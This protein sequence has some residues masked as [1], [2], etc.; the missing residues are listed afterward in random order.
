MLNAPQHIVSTILAS[1]DMHD[2]V[3]TLCRWFEAET[4]LKADALNAYKRCHQSSFVP[5]GWH[6]RDVLEGHLKS[7]EE[8]GKNPG[9]AILGD[10]VLIEFLRLEAEHS[11][12]TGTVV[13][14]MDGCVIEAADVPETTYNNWSKSA[15]TRCLPGLQQAAT[16]MR[17]EQSFQRST[18]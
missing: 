5:S 4:G 18:V 15:L 3:S 16:S 11:P 8:A 14:G 9:V 7:A 13:F 17:T 6:W 10:E 1:E 12:S 2:A